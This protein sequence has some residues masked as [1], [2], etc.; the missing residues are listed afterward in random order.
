[1][2]RGG[3]IY[4]EN[5]ESCTASVRLFEN[6]LAGAMEP[7][8]PADEIEKILGK[9][10]ETFVAILPEVPYIGGRDNPLTEDLLEAAYEMGFYP[11]MEERGW[12]LEEISRIDKAASRA[13]VRRKIAAL[14][15]EAVRGFVLDGKALERGS[16]AFGKMGFPDN[17]VYEV[18]VPGVDERF[19]TG[20]NYTKCPIVGLYRRFGRE[21]LLPFIC[22]N[23]FPVFE[24]MG[25]SLERSQTLAEGA[26]LCDFRF[27][28]MR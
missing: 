13:M 27:S 18:V 19:D 23:D 12:D 28:R 7:L 1:M 15:L 3:R 14:G 10:W 6:C 24:E 2:K 11:L 17:W 20:I 5:L 16:E 9:A 4:L 22:S 25:I 26:P 8:M 21:K